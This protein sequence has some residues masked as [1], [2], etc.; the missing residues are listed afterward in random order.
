MPVKFLTQTIV[1]PVARVNTEFK[2][3]E[4]DFFNEQYSKVIFVGFV[5][6]LTGP[7]FSLDLAF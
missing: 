1:T 4:L 2:I 6:N 5:T 7:F 3:I